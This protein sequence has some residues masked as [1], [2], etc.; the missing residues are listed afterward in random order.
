MRHLSL[1]I[2]ALIPLI[3]GCAETPAPSTE[4]TPAS[5]A[6]VQS[7]APSRISVPQGRALVYF[8]RPAVFA[9]SANTY[10]VS[11]DGRPVAD[12]RSGT[13][14]SV[15][16]S[17]GKTVLS[18]ETVPNPLNFGLGLAMMERPVLSVE[19]RAG[20]AV[21]VE[22]GTGFAGGPSF[23][24]TDEATALAKGA[25]LPTATATQ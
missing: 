22:I 15:P 12:I 8:F 1:A 23:T 9:G 5:V 6:P 3:A 24:L 16:V 11:I 18:A 14:A 25:S 7:T 10:R 21:F 17:P 20:T 4:A 19:A 2:A 13:R